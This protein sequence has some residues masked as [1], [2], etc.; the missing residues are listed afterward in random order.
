MEGGVEGTD[1]LTMPTATVAD[2][3][4]SRRFIEGVFKK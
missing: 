2:E 3:H 1:A 4:S